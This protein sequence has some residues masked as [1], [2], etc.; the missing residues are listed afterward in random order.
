MLEVCLFRRGR[1]FGT[2][3]KV[4]L[5]YSGGVIRRICYIWEGIL[6]IFGMCLGSSLEIGRRSGI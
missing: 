3:V 1:S 2:I 4:C 5:A 6:K